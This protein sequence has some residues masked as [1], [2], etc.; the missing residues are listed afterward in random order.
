V[1]RLDGTGAHQSTQT[2]AS[3]DALIVYDVAPGPSGGVHF[4][5][6]FVGT[7]DLGGG[8]LV[9]AGAS[10]DAFVGSVDAAGQHLASRRF[11]DGCDQAV[12]RMH[13]APG[14]NVVIVGQLMDSGSG[15][16]FGNGSMVSAGDED[17]F[18]AVLPP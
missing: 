4:G 15:A 11:G 5:G 1:V 8:P 2:F 17:V 16:D 14:G 7:A 10:S 18:V 12:Y 6:E 9:A 13:T 3:T